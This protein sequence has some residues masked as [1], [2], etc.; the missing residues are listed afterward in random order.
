METKCEYCGEKL[1][2][3]TWDGQYYDANGYSIELYDGPFG[4]LK[5]E[6]IE[7]CSEDCFFDSLPMSKKDYYR[8]ERRRLSYLREKD[9]GWED[10]YIEYRRAKGEIW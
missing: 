3:D 9:Y 1:L 4:G 10:E 7:C 8:E 2:Y 6:G 5:E